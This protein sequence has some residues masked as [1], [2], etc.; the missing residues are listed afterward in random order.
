MDV[1]KRSFGN[2]ELGQTVK[3]CGGQLIFAVKVICQKFAKVGKRS[4]GENRQ[5]D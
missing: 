2:I 5:D 1:W 3:A 4:S